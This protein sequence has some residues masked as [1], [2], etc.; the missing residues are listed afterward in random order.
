MT[1]LGDTIRHNYA[2]MSWCFDISQIV[3]HACCNVP[4]L[5]VTG[6]RVFYSRQKS[7]RSHLIIARIYYAYIKYFICLPL[8]HII[9][10]NP[11]HILRLEMRWTSWGRVTHICF[12]DPTVVGSE[13]GLSPGRRQAII[14]T[15]DWINGN[16]NPRNK[17]QWNLK[18]NSYILF[19]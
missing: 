1:K 13:N 15:I 19:Q 12:G 6:C 11:W 3:G 5:Y 16:S 10:N 9:I 2:M 8:V 14:W 18:R 17:L 4:V 7:N